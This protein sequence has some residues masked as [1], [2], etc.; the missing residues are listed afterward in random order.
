MGFQIWTVLTCALVETLVKPVINCL[1]LTWHFLLSLTWCTLITK[2]V[3]TEANHITPCLRTGSSS[4]CW[5]KSWVWTFLNVGLSCLKT[6]SLSS[7][8]LIWLWR[9]EPSKLLRVAAHTWTKRRGNA[10]PQNGLYLH[11]FYICWFA[12]IGENVEIITILELER[13][14]M[15]HYGEHNLCASSVFSLWCWWVAFSHLNLLM[16]H[17]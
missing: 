7:F 9:V 17:V 8:E 13:E 14:Y 16:V 5:V 11:I 3:R 4:G 12:H 10:S 6:S 15:H 2:P 1:L